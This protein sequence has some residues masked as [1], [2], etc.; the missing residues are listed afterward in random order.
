M[1]FTRGVS[2]TWKGAKAT[3][4][5]CC[6]DERAVAR[7]REVRVSRAL[8]GLALTFFAS[9]PRVLSLTMRDRRAGVL[10]LLLLLA[11]E[12]GVLL[13]WF[14]SLPRGP[15]FACEAALLLV[16]RTF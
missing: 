12:V 16:T 1:R 10:L 11:E 8:I 2:G 14:L 7:P 15:R 13:L 5:D 3:G 9:A 4:S 6:E